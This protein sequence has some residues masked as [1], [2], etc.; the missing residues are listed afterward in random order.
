MLEAY[1]KCLLCSLVKSGEPPRMPK[2]LSPPIA[3]AIKST[4]A[5]YTELADAFASGKQAELRAALDKHGAAFAA[6][7]NLGLAKQTLPALMRRAIRT[8]TDTYLTLS[9]SDIAQ[10][11]GLPDAAAAERQIRAMIVSD[12]IAAAIDQPRGMVHFLERAETYDSPETLAMM[13]RALQSAIA[14]NSKLHELHNSL[15]TDSLYLA[16]VSAQDR[17]PQWDEEAVLSK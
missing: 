6:D 4:L 13:E 17:Q 5:P 3:R 12:E 16:R 8:L 10:H 1:K 15:C 2:Y 9:L 7:H 11:A 14:L